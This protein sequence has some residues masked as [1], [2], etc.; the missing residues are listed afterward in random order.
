MRVV[1]NQAAVGGHHYALVHATGLPR[2]ATIPYDVRFFQSLDRIVQSQP[3][4]TRDKVMIDLLESIGIEPR[5]GGFCF[6]RGPYGGA[7]GWVDASGNGNNGTLTN[8]TVSDG[9]G[10]VTIG[11]ILGMAVAWFFGVRQE[12]AEVVGSDPMTDLGGTL[13]F[14]GGTGESGADLSR[15]DGTEAGTTLVVHAGDSGVSSDGYA[16]DGFAASFSGG[17]KPS[18]KNFAI[19]KAVHDFLL[20]MVLENQFA[21]FPNLRVASVENG[22]EFLPDLFRKLRSVDK[23]MQGWFKDDPVEIFKRHIWINPFW[24]DDVDEVVECMG[25]DR[26]LFGSDW[27]G[28]NASWY[29]ANPM[30][31]LYAAVTRQTLDGKPAGGWYPEQR[32]DLETSLRSYTVNNAWAEGEEANKGSLVAGKLADF[33]IIDRDLFAIPTT[34]IKDAKVLMTVVGGRIVHAAPPF[35]R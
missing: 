5:V 26:V 22:A 32:L 34:Q 7:V 33:V 28:T 24:E 16:V 11:A 12:R 23:K 4:L 2:D 21:K 15:S 8:A 29:T 10:V 20:S 1:G 25:A 17:F 30:T 18:L 31:I 27:P 13:L 9:T 19:E 3:W 14:Q 35:A 6:E